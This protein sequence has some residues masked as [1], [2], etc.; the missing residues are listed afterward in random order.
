MTWPDLPIARS[1]AAMSRPAG[2]LAGWGCAGAC[3]PRVLMRRKTGISRM[4]NRCMIASE[5]DYRAPVPLCS[6]SGRRGH[7]RANAVGVE[8]LDDEQL[9]GHRAYRAAVLRDELAR[10]LVAAH[11]QLVHFFVDPLRRRFAD[12]RAAI[13]LP[14]IAWCP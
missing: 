6:R 8:R 5:G 14:G 7:D 10:R 13:R 11:H 12:T 9:F 1:I 2:G 4:P 3:A